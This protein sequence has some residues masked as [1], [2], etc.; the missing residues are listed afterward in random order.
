MMFE[1]YKQRNLE[2]GKWNTFLMAPILADLRQSR[3]S[4][5]ARDPDKRF[6]RTFIDFIV[7]DCAKRNNPL[8]IKGLEVPS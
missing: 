6:Q 1:N 4:S 7:K 8:E 3:L 5:Y 2:Y